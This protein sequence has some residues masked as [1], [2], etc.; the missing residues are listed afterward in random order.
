MRVLVHAHR[1][2]RIPSSPVFRMEPQSSGTHGFFP[3]TQD[4]F[5]GRAHV[6]FY[7]AKRKSDSLV[8]IEWFA[9]RGDVRGR[10]IGRKIIERILSDFKAQGFKRVQLDS[11]PDAVGFWKKMGFVNLPGSTISPGPHRV[12]ELVRDL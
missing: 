8:E 7:R 11:A 3:E 4:L 6:G 9:I 1:R 2:R 5:L 12:V 10:G